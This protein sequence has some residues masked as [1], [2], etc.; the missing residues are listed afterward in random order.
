M[1]TKDLFLRLKYVSTSLAEML[2]QGASQTEYNSL[3]KY[4]DLVKEAGEI[5]K[6][7]ATHE[8]PKVPINLRKM[9]KNPFNLWF[10]SDGR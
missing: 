2:S 1:S 10:T 6:L 9:P 7:V 8:P 3:A 4:N 5:T